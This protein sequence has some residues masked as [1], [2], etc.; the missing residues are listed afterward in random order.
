MTIVLFLAAWLAVGAAPV[1]GAQSASAD[2][3]TEQALKTR[4]DAFF[5][6]LRRGDRAQLE[7][8]LAAGFTFSHSTGRLEEREEFIAR[9]VADAKRGPAPAIEFR[10]DHIRIYDGHTAV[11]TTRSLRHGGP[12]GDIEFRSTDVLVKTTGQWQWAAVHS[13]RLSR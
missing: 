5:E 7:P 1:P 13:T 8:F 2:A 3:Q 12:T 9:V 11:W 6:A 10:E 4:R